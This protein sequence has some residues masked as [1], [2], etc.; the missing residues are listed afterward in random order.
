[1]LVSPIPL[2]FLGVCSLSASSLWCISF[3][4]LKVFSHQ[5]Q[6]MVF[7]WGLSDGKSPQVFRT[8]LSNLADLNKS[9]VWIVSTR[10]AISKSP[11]SSTNLL[12]TVPRASIKI[13]IIV[14]FMFHYYYHYYYYYYYY[15]SL[16]VFHII[17]S[18]WYFTGVW[19]TAS[20]LQSPELFPVF[21]PISVML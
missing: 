5:S 3:Y 7:H 8:L 9:V 14:T 17:V 15:Y 2:S 12:M 19:L 13:I 4:S 18:W 6:L 21:W 16:R 10:P 20:L 11:S 1:M